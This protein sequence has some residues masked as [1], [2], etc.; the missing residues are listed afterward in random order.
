MEKAQHAA[1]GWIQRL[2]DDVGGARRQL[3]HP[4]RLSVVA[5]LLEIALVVLLGSVESGSGS[6]LGDDGIGEPA[7]YGQ[8]LYGGFGRSLLL[9]IVKKHG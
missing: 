2:A 3:P 5:V 9:G 6:Y 8:A 1:A 7:G 4:L